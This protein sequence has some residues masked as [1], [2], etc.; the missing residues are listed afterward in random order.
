MWGPTLKRKQG[1]PQAHWEPTSRGRKRGEGQGSGRSKDRGPPLRLL[2]VLCREGC[3]QSARPQARAS[4]CCRNPQGAVLLLRPASDTAASPI[5]HRCY[6]VL[7]PSSRW[8]PRP[9]ALRLSAL[10]LLG[11]AVRRSSSPGTEP[12][13][14]SFPSACLAA[15]PPCAQHAA[16][17]IYNSSERLHIMSSAL[18]LQPGCQL[19]LGTPHPEQGP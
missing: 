13:S 8:V 19:A 12:E 14:L 7:P 1:F 18:P 15:L 10:S 3:P 4:R 11:R 2:S 9:L 5:R 16:P 6:L 17:T